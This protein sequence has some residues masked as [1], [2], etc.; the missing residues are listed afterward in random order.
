MHWL[1]EWSSKTV[2]IVG[3]VYIVVDHCPTGL[4]AVVVRENGTLEHV[5]IQHLRNVRCTKKGL[6]DA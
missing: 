3:Y 1:A 6:R 2:E 5:M 4:Y